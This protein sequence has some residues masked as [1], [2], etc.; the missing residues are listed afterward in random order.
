MRDVMMDI[1]TM[2]TDSNAVVVSISCVEFDLE[3]GEIGSKFERGLKLNP[4]VKAGGVVDMNTVMWWMEQSD[5][6]RAALTFY[7]RKPVKEVL[8]EL[9]TWLGSLHDNIKD[10]KLWGNGATFDNVIVR[11]LCK[12]H[13][14]ELMVPFWCDNDVRTLVTLSGINTRDYEFTG[15][16]HHGIDDC[17]H[18]IKYCVDGYNKLKGAE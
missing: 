16:K 5:E 17:K 1:E 3:T 4:Q 8:M 9:N 6:A 18:Q 11:N 15:V 13:D 7:Y 10:L 2:S 12:R 14:M